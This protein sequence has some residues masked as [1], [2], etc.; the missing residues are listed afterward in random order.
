MYTGAKKIDDYSRVD[1]FLIAYE[2]GSNFECNF[3][4]SLIRHIEEK[5]GTPI[6]S[7]GLNEQI[8]LAAKKSKQSKN[9]LFLKESLLI[10]IN[11][12]DSDNKARFANHTREE[13]INWLK[14]FPDKINI[15]W[16]KKF[17][18]CYR[19]IQEWKGVQ[20]TTV[21]M[22]LAV[23][24]INYIEDLIKDDVTKLKDVPE[25]I[26]LLNIELASAL[27]SNKQNN[28]ILVA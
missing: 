12:S 14:N 16:L 6:P 21:E 11:E 10:L 27:K 15:F 26:Q 17:K 9:Q 25:S 8:R 1:I 18:D 19:E 28:N 23:K 22:N 13:M 3:R 4:Q 7:K 5:Y 24:L 20:L 2:L